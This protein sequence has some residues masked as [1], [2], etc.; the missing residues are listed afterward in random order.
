[1]SNLMNE[2]NTDK[3]G[4]LWVNNICGRIKSYTDY[5]YRRYDSKRDHS[6]INKRCGIYNVSFNAAA[7]YGEKYG[8][9][10]TATIS[11]KARDILPN[12][13]HAGRSNVRLGRHDDIVHVAINKKDENG[14]YINVDMPVY[15]FA[16]LIDRSAALYKSN[17]MHYRDKS[18]VDSKA[19][20]A[21]GY[22]FDTN[23]E[24]FS[25]SAESEPDVESNDGPFI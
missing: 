7:D 16:G 6:V 3:R 2:V 4:M 17:H 25:I 9:D 24:L 23:N 5:D 19:N 1:M 21:N 20:P 12:K 22:T 13:Y 14:V 15:K 10:V 8:D 18:D 11:V